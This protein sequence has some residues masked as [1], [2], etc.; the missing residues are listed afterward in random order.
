MLFITYDICIFT[1]NIPKSYNTI[2]NFI[3]SI[4]IEVC[5]NYCAFKYY[6]SPKT[7]Y[8]ETN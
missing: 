2:S 1:W 5:F 7:R 4:I 3:L 8:K 6:A